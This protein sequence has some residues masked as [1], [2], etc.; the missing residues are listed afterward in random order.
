MPYRYQTSLSK[1]NYTAGS[2]EVLQTS[3]GRRLCLRSLW[4]NTR[5]PAQESLIYLPSSDLRRLHREEHDAERLRS[6][7]GV[8][9]PHR[10]GH[11]AR[12]RAHQMEPSPL[13]QRRQTA[14]TRVRRRRGKRRSAGF[15]LIDLHR[16]IIPPELPPR[17]A[18]LT[19]SATF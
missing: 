14:G 12:V 7:R 1:L 13:L 18:Q 10:R 3:S 16:M 19:L 11:V 8:R 5:L 6:L 9:Q 15:P 4:T 2:Y 17:C